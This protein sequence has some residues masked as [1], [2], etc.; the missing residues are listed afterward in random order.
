MLPESL[1]SKLEALAA[2]ERLLPTVI[3]VIS[4]ADNSVVYMSQS[5]LSILGVSM[6]EL[7]AMGSEYHER[8]FNAEDAKD[9]VPKILGMVER[10]NNEEEVT[11]FQQV[12][13]AECNTFKWYSS[14]TKIFM[15]DAA[16]KPVM[17]ITCANAIEDR[18]YMAG[19][20]KRILNE[21][22]F[23]RQHAELFNELSRREKEVLAL[24]A[25]GFTS[26][27][28]S[29]KL[30]ISKMTALTHRRNIKRKLM[31]DSDYELTRFA[32]AFDLITSPGN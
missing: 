1:H 15:R 18:H 8:F 16:G 29:D 6:D 22:D 25:A 2:A 7:R 13:H 9:Y 17:T 19:K 28:I 23:V 3:I 31:A 11:C 27:E 24:V 10:N 5:G 20:A 4:L 21:S 30:C 26:P 14:S 32:H 12:L